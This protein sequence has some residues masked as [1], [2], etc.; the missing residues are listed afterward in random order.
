MKLSMMCRLL[1]SNFLLLCRFVSL[2]TCQYNLVSFLMLCLALFPAALPYIFVSFL[3]LCLAL[4]LPLLFSVI[5]TSFSCSV[6]L[7][8]RLFVTDISPDYSCSQSLSFTLNFA[9]S[10]PACF[11]VFFL[12]LFLFFPRLSAYAMNKKIDFAVGHVT[13]RKKHPPNKHCTGFIYLSGPFVIGCPVV[14]RA[15]G[16]KESDVIT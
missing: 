4:S 12:S 6:L 3:V 8:L 10:L 14:L 15:D 5:F 11:L 9:Y 13:S 2:A 1:K 16:R 7:F